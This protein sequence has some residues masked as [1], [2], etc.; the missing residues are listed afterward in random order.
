M[1]MMS[2]VISKISLNLLKFLNFTRAKI[3]A[4]LVLTKRKETQKNCVHPTH[5]VLWTLGMGLASRYLWLAFLMS[6]MSLMIS[7]IVLNL[8]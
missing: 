4:I 3:F 2:L 1:S 5:S 8:L 6:M 7:R